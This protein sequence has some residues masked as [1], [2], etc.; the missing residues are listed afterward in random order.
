VA[1]RE[2]TGPNASPECA[3]PGAE[4]KRYPVLENWKICTETEDLRSGQPNTGSQASRAESA[5]Q[6]AP[7]ILASV[8][9]VAQSC[10]RFS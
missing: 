5:D 8:A 4:Q 7:G 6:A 1:A 10:A 2:I 3:Y 9:G